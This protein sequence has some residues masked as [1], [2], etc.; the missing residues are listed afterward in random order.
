LL[1]VSKA[2]TSEVGVGAVEQVSP[3]RTLQITP[4]SVDAAPLPLDPVE[5]AHAIDGAVTPRLRLARGAVRTRGTHAWPPRL[6]RSARTLGTG[7]VREFLTRAMHSEEAPALQYIAGLLET[8]A[9]V[10]SIYVDLLAPA[11]RMLGE[12]WDAD[13]C[14]FV[15]VTVAVGR[16]QLILRSLSRQF[17]LAAESPERSGHVLLSGIPGEQHTLGLFMVA[18][19]FVRDGWAVTIGA[20]VAECDLMAL[21]STQSFDIVGFSIARDTRLARLKREIARLRQH[22]RNRQ[23]CVVVGGRL[24]AEYPQV[25]ARIG[26]DAPASD[27]RTGPIV[28]R[29]LLAGLGA[30]P[31]GEPS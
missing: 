24:V 7:E 25:A 30:S 6:L 5:L 27:A 26:A 10:E 21:V 11:A 9:T 16:V 23:V 22:S 17:A 18:E 4:R 13:Q 2:R 15:D 3:E 1:V 12:F 29:R 8:G 28:A 31:L 20:P 19:F 14:D